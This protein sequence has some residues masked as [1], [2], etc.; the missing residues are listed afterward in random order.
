MN[1]IVCSRFTLLALSGFALAACQGGSDD[2]A[3]S[4]SSGPA[5]TVHSKPAASADQPAASANKAS[6]SPGKPSAP[7]NIDY[8]I[9]G[10]PVVGIPLSINVKISSRLDQPIRVNYRINDSTSLM[11][12]DAQS[13][14]VSLLPDGDE[15]YS[16]EQVTVI[17]QREGRLFLNVSAE[18][19]TDIGMMARVMAIP[20][21][22]GNLRP[23][24]QVNG[25]LTTG[26]D[27]EA[28]ISMP[29]KEE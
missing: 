1:R 23:T 28:L 5:T 8:E 24:P 18:I 26:E 22:V 2:V 7:I 11:F 13:E 6:K 4:G 10:V 9:M 17:P 15:A 25:Q 21:Q 12:S 3:G 19:E 27:G 14:T 29:A 20:I 16:A